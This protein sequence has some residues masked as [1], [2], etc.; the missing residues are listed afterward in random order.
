MR[1]CLSSALSG[2]G[3]GQKLLP[4]V[5]LVCLLCYLLL[6]ALRYLSLH[7]KSSAQRLTTFPFAAGRRNTSGSSS[8]GSNSAPGSCVRPVAARPEGTA[9]GRPLPPYCGV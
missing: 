6:T 7:L 8:S 9:A 2:R 4:L 5:M 1:G 3:Y